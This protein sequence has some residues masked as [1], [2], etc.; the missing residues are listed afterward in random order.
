SRAQYGP[1]LRALVTYLTQQQLLP[2]GRVR[3]L[4]ADVLGLAVSV[5]TLV[6]VVQRG[7][8]A[9]ATTTA[10]IRARLAGEPVQHHDETG[11]RVQGR[12]HWLHVQS[13]ARYT[14]YALHALHA[15]RGG[16]AM[17]AVDQ[18]E[19]TGVHVH[20]G[21]A[22]YRRLAGRHALCNVHH[23]R[24]L[25][26]LAEEEQQAWATDLKHLLQAMK[27]AVA[28]ARAAGQTQ[29]PEA[30]RR[31]WHA[32]YH[33][34]V[35]AGVLATAAPAA[36][37]DAHPPDTLSRRRGRRKQSPARNLLGRLW[38][39]EDQVLAFLD[40]F[41]VPFDNNQAERDLRMVKVQQKVSGTFRSP[42]GADA[43]CAL[44]GILS[45]LRKPGYALLTALEAAFTGHPLLP[46]GVPE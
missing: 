28:Q 7:A 3:D 17:A 30:D 2:Y 9:V 40:D 10:A 18:P 24:E 39:Y 29:L 19:F 45:T 6:G 8:Q 5:G 42:A 20:D 33:A 23:L 14:A 38:A 27:T 21:W 44:R 41:T 46:Q 12:L 36:E 34:L 16:A 4:L 37:P 26:Y 1:R 31:A 15:Q 32:R 25:T 43:F 13:S 35:V 11:A 22:A